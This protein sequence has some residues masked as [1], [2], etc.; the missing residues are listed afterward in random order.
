MGPAGA[1]CCSVWLSLTKPVK[2]SW[3]CL[4]NIGEPVLFSKC[5]VILESW[6]VK[7]NGVIWVALGAEESLGTEW[8]RSAHQVCA[9]LGTAASIP[10]MVPSIKR[11]GGRAWAVTP[12]LTDHE[13]KTS[14]C[15]LH[16]PYASR[17]FQLQFA[18]FPEKYGAYES[19]RIFVCVHVL[20]F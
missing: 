4:G 17:L 14:V 20:F 9:R 10:T 6:Q 3:D 12:G 19:R 18:H 13:S 1:S 15:L 5:W 2:L 16:K 7:A 8:G 11:D